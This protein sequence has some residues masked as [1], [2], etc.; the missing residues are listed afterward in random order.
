MRRIKF[1]ANV[2]PNS[3]II[4]IIDSMTSVF[5]TDASLPYNHD[6]FESL[7]V[8]KRIKM[9]GKGNYCCLT[10]II[11]SVAYSRKLRIY[12]MSEGYALVI[13]GNRGNIWL[14][15]AFVGASSSS[16]SA[17][18]TAY[19]SYSG[20]S[21]HS[22]VHQRIEKKQQLKMQVVAELTATTLSTHFLLRTSG[23]PVVV[24]VLSHRAK[25]SL[26]DWIPV[27]CRLCA[28]RLAT[29]VKESLKGGVGLCLS[30]APTAVCLQCPQRGYKFGRKISG[31]QRA[32]KFLTINSQTQSLYQEKRPM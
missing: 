28:V 13:P 4:I 17:V 2:C 6:L 22:F 9:D 11:P 12:H 32:L 24:I 26:I 10:T 21:C 29:F 8:K 20:R 15:V 23:N 14:V 31:G 30:Y 19:L 25:A 27:A 16:L 5:N 3:S 1:S 18:R 7:I